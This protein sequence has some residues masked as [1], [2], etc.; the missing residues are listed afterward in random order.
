[1]RR[2]FL[3]AVIICVT[4]LLHASTL[5]AVLDPIPMQKIV[6]RQILPGDGYMFSHDI[7][8]FYAT[9]YVSGLLP[10]D[11]SNKVVWSFLSRNGDG[12]TVGF[13]KRGIFHL[14]TPYVA[15][16]LVIKACYAGK[17]GTVGVSLEQPY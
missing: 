6:V 9:C 7:G 17:C 4:V 3:F 14:I 1:M 16:L 5:M 13:Y 11:C 12:T 10:E 8:Q 2:P 15:D